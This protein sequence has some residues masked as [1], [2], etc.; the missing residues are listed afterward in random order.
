MER[1]RGLVGKPGRCVWHACRVLWENLKER[2][3]LQDQIVDGRLILKV[4][5]KLGGRSWTGLIWLR[6][7]TSVT[8]F[9]NTVMDIQIS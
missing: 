2:D 4:L 7:G 3:H 5:N 8:L 6:I 1:Y 9:L